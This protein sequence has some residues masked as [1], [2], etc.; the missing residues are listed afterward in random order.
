[1][2]QESKQRCSGCSRNLQVGDNALQVTEGVVSRSNLVPLEDPV[3]FCNVGCLFGYF[4]D[5][6]E[7]LPEAPTR[8]P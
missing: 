5:L 8:T 6:L 1:M 7:Y 2:E 4:K 3:H